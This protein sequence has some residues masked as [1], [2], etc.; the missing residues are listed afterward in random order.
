MNNFVL[1]SII[2]FE[3]LEPLSYKE[4]FINLTPHLKLMIV[5]P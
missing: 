5:L 1:T 3:I 4:L 2:T